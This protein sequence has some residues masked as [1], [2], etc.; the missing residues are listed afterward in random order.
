MASLKLSRRDLGRTGKEQR[1]KAR[2]LALDVIE[3]LATTTKDSEESAEKTPE[4]LTLGT[5]A[6]LYERDGLYGVGASYAQTQVTKV[7]RFATFLGPD[8]PVVSLCKSDV[9]RFAAHRAAKDGVSMNTV[10][11]DL[12]GLKIALNFATEY[13]RADGRT[14]LAANPLQRV[15]LPREEPRRPWATA[16]WPSTE[17]PS[18]P[19]TLRAVS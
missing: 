19:S 9:K 8:R 4:C 15:R 17:P 5:L 10:A 2:A 7:R 18:G 13:R 1:E 16:D 12:K 11:G 14:L 3:A 6:D